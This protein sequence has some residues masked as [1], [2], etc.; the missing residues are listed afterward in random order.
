MLIGELFAGPQDWGHV[1]LLTHEVEKSK[2][3]K[4]F[5]DALADLNTDL[6]EV[7]PAF[8]GAFALLA[9]ISDVSSS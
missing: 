2:A 9:G 1:N 5:L 3:S 8:Q 4:E 7:T 6:P